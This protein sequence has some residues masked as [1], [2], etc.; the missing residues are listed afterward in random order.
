MVDPAILLA[1]AVP[2]ALLAM[3]ADIALG[4]LRG[5]AVPAGLR[6]GAV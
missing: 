1:G 6:V 5:L 2:V 3:G 4:R